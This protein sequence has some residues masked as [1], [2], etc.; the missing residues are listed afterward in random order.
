M[1][2]DKYFFNI[3]EEVKKKSKDNNTHVNSNRIWMMIEA[4]NGGLF[5]SCLSTLLNVTS[6]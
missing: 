1:R 4:D 6:G 2:W 3:A 5:R